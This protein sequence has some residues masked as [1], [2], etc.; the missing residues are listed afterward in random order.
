[1]LDELREGDGELQSLSRGC[2]SRAGAPGHGPAK[3]VLRTLEHAAPGDTLASLGLGAVPGAA[4]T[5]VL[6]HPD[7]RAR[8]TAWCFARALRSSSRREQLRANPFLAC[9]RAEW[10][11]LSP[12]SWCGGGLLR[13]TENGSCACISLGCCSST[14]PLSSPFCRDSPSQEPSGQ[15][16][17]WDGAG[18]QRGSLYL[19]G[20][21]NCKSDLLVQYTIDRFALATWSRVSL[22]ASYLMASY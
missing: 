7:R 12:G 1:M 5:A 6:Q 21:N 13:F 11:H 17:C 14:S 19:A 20:D 4:G 16:L 18:R 3:G 9:L 22:C 2:R 10:C 8:L 15:P